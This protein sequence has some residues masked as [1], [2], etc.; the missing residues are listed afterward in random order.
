MPI[1]PSSMSFSLIPF[2]IGASTDKIKSALSPNTDPFPTRCFVPW[3]GWRLLFVGGA[4]S[5][6]RSVGCIASELLLRKALFPG[7]NGE[8]QL[9]LI[10]DLLGAPSAEDMESLR[11]ARVLL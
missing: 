4:V 11:S 2:A 1:K 8:A 10:T 6:S 7:K 5:P 9:R 3:N